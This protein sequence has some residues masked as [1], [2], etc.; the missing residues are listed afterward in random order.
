MFLKKSILDIKNGGHLYFFGA[1]QTS[2][3]AE[4]EPEIRS[5]G[6]NA[7]HS[8]AASTADTENVAV[9][10]GPRWVGM[11]FCDG[12]DGVCEKKHVMCFYDFCSLGQ[13]LVGRVLP[14][15]PPKKVAFFF[16]NPQS[17]C[18]SLP[19]PFATSTM[20]QGCPWHLQR[21]A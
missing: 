13:R 16:K 8:S 1:G 19:L 2:P 18:D 4:P 9:G 12:G 11:S 5:D 17:Y 7:P 21:Q 3:V 14:F 6:E 15:A 20:C 10:H